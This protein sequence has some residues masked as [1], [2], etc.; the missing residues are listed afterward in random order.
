MKKE[1][2]YGDNENGELTDQG[3]MMLLGDMGED[4]RPEVEQLRTAEKRICKKLRK[5]QSDLIKAIASAE[6]LPSAIHSFV[7][8]IRP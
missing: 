3:Q 7:K 2:Q 5:L 6:D 4:Y 8:S 1:L